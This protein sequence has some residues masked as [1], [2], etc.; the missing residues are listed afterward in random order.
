[1]IIRKGSFEGIENLPAGARAW[2]AKLSETIKVQT[3]N[4]IDE[5]DDENHQH[6][7]KSAMTFF[8]SLSTSH[9]KSNNPFL[10]NGETRIKYVFL[11]TNPHWLQMVKKKNKFETGPYFLRHWLVVRVFRLLFGC[12]FLLCWKTLK[13][14]TKTKPRKRWTWKNPSKV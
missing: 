11:I 2:A 3:N 12:N 13:D 4:N 1:M 8:L 7:D 5:D 14:E 10:L 9:V 6:R